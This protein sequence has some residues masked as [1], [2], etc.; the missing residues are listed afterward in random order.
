ML[1]TFRITKKILSLIEKSLRKPCCP[2]YHQSH[3]GEWS[4]VHLCKEQQACLHYLYWVSMVGNPGL[5][6]SR[7]LLT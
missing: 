4:A 2:E 1:K 7:L 3:C 5:I 6:E